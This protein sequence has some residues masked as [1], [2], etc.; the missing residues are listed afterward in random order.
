MIYLLT[1]N[2]WQLYFAVIFG[3]QQIRKMGLKLKTLFLQGQK[4]ILPL[5][6]SLQIDHIVASTPRSNPFWHF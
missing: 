4:H 2:K 1:I 6:Q 3:S 5:T